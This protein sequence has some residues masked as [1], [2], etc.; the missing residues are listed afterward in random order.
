MSS[1]FYFPGC[2]THNFGHSATILYGELY[3]TLEDDHHH[4][5]IHCHSFQ[6]LWDKYSELLFSETTR[7][8]SDSI[9][10]ISTLSH[11]VCVTRHLFRDDSW[12]PGAFFTWDSF[13]HSYPK[14]SLTIHSQP[15]PTGTG[16]L[17]ALHC[18]TY[19]IRLTPRIARIW[20]NRHSGVSF[21]HFKAGCQNKT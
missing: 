7:I 4:I 10:L 17:L 16:F 6:D 9:S 12:P 8:L 13:L 19:A 18:H 14:P 1:P 2:F 5:F 20:G 15:S 3:G 11:L 21:D